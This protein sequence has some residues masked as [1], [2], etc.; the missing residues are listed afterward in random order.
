MA[1]A[2]YSTPAMQQWTR[3]KQQFPDCVLFF[4]MG[5]FFELF[6]PDAESMRLGLGWAARGQ[7]RVVV[8]ERAELCHVR[9]SRAC[10]S[11]AMGD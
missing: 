9:E 7:L 4:R 5:D 11:T 8:A 6:G 3:C 1:K 10:G 2:P